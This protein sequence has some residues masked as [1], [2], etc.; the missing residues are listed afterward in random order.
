MAKRQVEVFVARCP[1]C[2]PTLR[3]VRELASACPDCELTVHDL[4]QGGAGA[5]ARYGIGSVPA[6]VVDGV[7]AAGTAGRPIGSR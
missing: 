6:V 5:A 1:V 3:L 4:R 2:E 7:L